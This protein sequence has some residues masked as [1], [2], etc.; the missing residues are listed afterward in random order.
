MTNT[1]QIEKV[2]DEK[3]THQDQIVSAQKALLVDKQKVNELSAM[4]AK[5]SEKLPAFD[6]VLKL[7]GELE[8][9]RTLLKQQQAGSKAL[10][11]IKDN[12]AT[13]RRDLNDSRAILSQLLVHF[14]AKY[15]QRS[16]NLSYD[17]HEIDM[18]A[19]IGKKLE[20]QEVLP[21]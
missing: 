6:K 20:K 13:A 7:E 18:T 10:N 21:L 12:L 11:D 4:A 14:V 8:A 16:V 19:K 9:A 17:F 15:Q 1:A 3:Q 2:K 5:E